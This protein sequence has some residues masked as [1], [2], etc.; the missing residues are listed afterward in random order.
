MVLEVGESQVVNGRTWHRVVFDETLRYPERVTS[1]WYVAGDYVEVFFDEGPQ[2]LWEHGAS[3]TDKRIEVSCAE[4]RLRAYEGDALMLDIA[5]STGLP[6]TPTPKGAFEIYQKL[7]SRYMQGPLPGLASDQVYDMPGVPWNL[8]FTD[9]GA[10]VHGTYWHT[11]FGSR[12]SHG[13]VNL[14]PAA[15]R[16]LYEW[17]ELGTPVEVY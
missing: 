7:P 1:D 5:I 8:Y 13:C 16:D 2:T 14:P 12:Y 9:G 4:Q 3:S 6:L 17:A 10:V 15:A 11:S